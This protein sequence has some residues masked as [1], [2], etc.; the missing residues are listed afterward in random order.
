M[1]QVLGAF[2]LLDFTMLRPILA[3]RAF[4]NLRTV[5]LIFQFFF[6]AAANRG[7]G[8][9]PVTAYVERLLA[10]TNVPF[11]FLNCCNGWKNY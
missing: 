4:W 6:R 8:G 9:P 3:W 11:V 7:Y 1:S 2:G 10:L 5:S